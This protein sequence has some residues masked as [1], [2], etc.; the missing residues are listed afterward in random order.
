MPAFRTYKSESFLS[1]RV[2]NSFLFPEYT[3]SLLYVLWD[4]KFQGI[5]QKVIRSFRENSFNVDDTFMVQY[6]EKYISKKGSEKRNF[7]KYMSKKYFE[8][9]DFVKLNMTYS[10]KMPVT[11]N[12]C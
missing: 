2:V 4:F 5:T 10:L 8:K 7:E 1:K 12:V 9:R 6:F 3:K 11:N